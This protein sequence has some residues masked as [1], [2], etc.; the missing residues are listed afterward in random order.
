MNTCQ[1]LKK[2]AMFFLKNNGKKYFK[3]YCLP[4]QNGSS[5]T[6]GRLLLVIAKIII[7]MSQ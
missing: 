3:K 2:I 5:L 6:D 1:V 7:K 4:M